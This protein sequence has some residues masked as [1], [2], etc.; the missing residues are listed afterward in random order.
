MI[1]RISYPGSQGEAEV[2]DIAKLAYSIA[3]SD[4]V[5]ANAYRDGHDSGPSSVIIPREGRMDS[6][7]LAL[8]NV[9]HRDDISRESLI[10]T[11]KWLQDNAY[12][13][14]KASA[15]AYAERMKPIW[16]A[17]NA[18]WNA[19]LVRPAGHPNA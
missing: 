1:A 8:F 2:D 4:G 15:A 7:R 14:P 3:M 12:T 19:T 18:K 5:L 11:M 13:E 10:D 17:L 16:D 6:I 9:D